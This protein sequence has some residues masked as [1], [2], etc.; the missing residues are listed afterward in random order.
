MTFFANGRLTA[1]FPGAV[2]PM[3]PAIDGKWCMT[4]PS[5]F[6]YQFK[7]LITQDGKIVAYVAPHIDAYLTSATT[8]EAGGVGVAY[9]VAT[10][11]PLPGQYNVTETWATAYSGKS[12]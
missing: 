10:G 3:Q 1:T 5:T 9:S 2:P 7:E 4:G 6:R 12:A 11:Q 8:F